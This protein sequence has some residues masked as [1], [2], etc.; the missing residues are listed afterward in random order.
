LLGG[1]IAPTR[2]DGTR[3][4]QETRREIERLLAEIAW[5]CRVPVY[6]SEDV[7]GFEAWPNPPANRPV[8]FGE[9][10]L[11]FPVHRRSWSK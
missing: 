7:Q 4:L 2:G 6:H 11:A 10:D 8:G 5:R 1:A 9:H 3:D